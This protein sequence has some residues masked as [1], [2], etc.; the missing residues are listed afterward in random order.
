MVAVIGLLAE[1]LVGVTGLYRGSG[2]PSIS[3]D[4]SYKIYG[5]LTTIIITVM[6]LCACA[7]GAANF[8]S[9]RGDLVL[10]VSSSLLSQLPVSPVVNMLYPC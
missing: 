8:E 7:C 9:W 6:I 4:R 3:I 2:V 10:G 5:L 1:V